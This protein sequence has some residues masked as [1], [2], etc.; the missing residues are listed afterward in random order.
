M[1]NLLLFYC[2][3]YIIGKFWCLQPQIF[4]LCCVSSVGAE[5]LTRKVLSALCC[6]KT[7]WDGAAVQ[8]SEQLQDSGISHLSAVMKQSAAVRIFCLCFT[9]LCMFKWLAAQCFQ[10]LFTSDSDSFYTTVPFWFC[11]ALS[12]GFL[13][14]SHSWSTFL[15]GTLTVCPKSLCNCLAKQKVKFS[16]CDT[17]F[18]LQIFSCLLVSCVRSKS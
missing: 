17:S 7:V 1:P 2:C 3:S 9:K 10:Q 5:N 8:V 12:F 11:Q 16:C 18:L 6:W 13:V 14:I 4:F 15:F